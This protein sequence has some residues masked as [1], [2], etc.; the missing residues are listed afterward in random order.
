[1]VYKRQAGTSAPLW[2][3]AIPLGRDR[4]PSWRTGIV[5]PI[6]AA[7]LDYKYPLAGTGAPLW[8]TAIPLGG[9]WYPSW[10]TGTV[11]PIHAAFL[12]WIG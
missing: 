5:L 9:D 6:Y 8:G 7:L 4:Y 10:R 11:L 1:D 12:D 3:T 2:G